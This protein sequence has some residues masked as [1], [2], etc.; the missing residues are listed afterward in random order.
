VTDHAPD[1]TFL[2]PTPR[3]VIK[4]TDLGATAVLRLGALTLVAD[5]FGD[6]RP[7][8]RGLGLYL[9]DTRILSTLEVLVDGRRPTLLEPDLGGRERG[10]IQM[11]NPELRS[12]PTR[13][14]NSAT[15]ATQ[16]L[17]IRR[18]RT[19][20]GEGMHER[21]SIANYTL[22]QQELTVDVL[23]DA[24]G[25]DIFEVRGY[26]R[27][28]RG[29]LEPIE[30]DPSGPRFTYVSRDGLALHTS[31]SFDPVPETLTPAPS[32]SQASV[33]ASWSIAI[34]P[35]EAVNLS[36]QI[37]GRWELDL[38][39]PGAAMDQLH[40]AR[41]P[42]EHGP[43]I[44]TRFESDDELVN[45]MLAR[46]LADIRLLET[47]GPGTGEFFVAA[48]VPWFATLFGRD[49]IISAI[50]MLPVLPDIARS[51]LDVL[52][53]LQATAVDDWHDAEPG[54]IIHEFRTGEMA[55]IGALPFSA[56]YGSADATPLFLLLLAETHAWTGEDALVDRLWPNVTAAIDWMRGPAIVDG[57]LRYATRSER[58]L[59]NQ[60]WKDSHDSVRDRDG[61]VAEPPIA[62][63]EVQCYA[64]AAY[65]EM[66]IHADRRGEAMFAAELRREAFELSEKVE[67]LFWLPELQRYAMAIDGSNRPA[68]ALASNVGHGL[69]TGAL[70]PEHAGAV[71]RDLAGPRMSSGWGLRSY[72][73]GQ[74]GYNPLGYHLGTVWPHDTAIAVAGLK[75]YGFTTEATELG[76]GLLDAAR[77]LP[78]FRFPELF[79]G[80]PRADTGV[81]VT[82]PVACAPQAWAAS[83]P[84]ML[85]QALLGLEADAPRHELRINRPTLPHPIR[86]LVVA[87]LRVGDAEVDLLFQS[88]RGTTGAEVLRR[89]GDLSIAVRL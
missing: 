13:R 68:D 58:G 15:L 29:V 51:T 45:L 38:E 37:A 34:H 5:P 41:R 44:A 88:W 50:F 83:S 33:R 25:A 20:S 40:A 3:R 55:R 57:L 53:R 28:D 87:G 49:A 81:P 10:T 52:A 78:L 72:A 16:S 85:F 18:E 22:V 61:A 9:G 63:L 86:K 82:Y 4:A 74:P 62:L 7:D 27:A 71:A 70:N 42:D 65:R 35:G 1:R 77:H 36:W 32:G 2:P 17:G 26:A 59:R 75:R 56:Y 24:D 43:S 39:R 89:H 12:D 64:I 30:V 60:G 11:T 8:S 80:F 79:C 23:L 31:V 73:Q 69:W 46:G 19:L 84:F 47:A 48:G 21:L 14:A 54:K 6:L 76:K 66:A 67:S